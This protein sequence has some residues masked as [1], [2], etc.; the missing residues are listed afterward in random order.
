MGFFTFSRRTHGAT[1]DAADP[2][3]SHVTA[4]VSEIAGFGRHRW[5]SA[6][7]VRSTAAWPA[8]A[9][10]PPEVRVAAAIEA[11]TRACDRGN[12]RDFVRATTLVM[13]G[14]EVLRS[15]LALTA[16]DRVALLQA[17]MTYAA[18]GSGSARLEAG[19]DHTR[20][21]LRALEERGG[22]VTRLPA[23]E[24]LLRQVRAALIAG[25]TAESK[26]CLPRVDALLGVTPGDTLFSNPDW[27]AR[28]IEGRLTDMEPGAREAGVAALRLATTASSARPSQKFLAQARELASAHGDEVV[29]RALGDLLRSGALP[30]TGERGQVDPITGDALRG[31]CWVASVLTPTPELAASVGAWVTSGWIK[32][33]GLGPRCRKAA[34]G[35]IWALA[36]LGE[37]GAAQLGRARALVK[38]PQAVAEIEAAIEAVAEALDIPREEFEERVVPTYDL[39]IGAVSRVTMGDFVATLGFDRGKAG[40]SI[41]GPDGR[42]RKT[43]PA[44]VREGYSRELA[45]LKALAKDVSAMVVAQKLR[46]ERLL[47]EERRWEATAW[48]ERYLDHPLNP[49]V[50]RPLIWQ[51]VDPHG[52]V[53]AFIAQDGHPRDVHGDDVAVDGRIGLWHPATAATADVESWRL[54]I[55]ELGLVQPFKQAH[56]E[57][58]LLTD[59]ERSTDIYSNRFAGH[60]LRQHQ[61][62][63]LARARGWRYALQ[64]AWDQPDGQA[65]LRLSQ[66][67]V[68]V[69]FWVDRPWD[70]PTTTGTTRACSTTCSATRCA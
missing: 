16:E 2:A 31:L 17:L 19:W 56:R 63:A 14:Q 65:T 12:D 57:V 34:S 40:I 59:A 3:S 54:R 6:D 69:G 49:V 46:L 13:I 39:E 44:A 55:E 38:Q 35:A 1:E 4:I 30:V 41:T 61:F 64:G 60:I 24:S 37:P 23:E 70:V 36:R 27:C 42:V 51:A 43:V 62:A 47:M 68:G 25:D 66:H 52:R 29:A 32:I 9:A 45:E 5:P 33:P 67:G 22:E 15:K 53:T 50:A 26:R 48:R 18:R 10:A 28:A 58:Y 7:E 8:L 21:V 11:F 20:S